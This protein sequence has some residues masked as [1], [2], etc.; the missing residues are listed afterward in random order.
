VVENVT[1]CEQS[2]AP[3][4][5]VFPV[6]SREVGG[7][8]MKESNLPCGGPAFP[9]ISMT[10]ILRHRPRAAVQGNYGRHSRIYKVQTIAHPD[11]QELLFRMENIKWKQT[12]RNHAHEKVAETPSFRK[13][14]IVVLKS[15]NLSVS[16]FDLKFLLYLIHVLHKK[17]II[18]R[19][20]FST[21][22]F[23]HI[24]KNTKISK[25]FLFHAIKSIYGIFGTF[26]YFIMWQSFYNIE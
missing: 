25:I 8:T 5:L 24:L 12:S 26:A 1:I 23:Q 3:P 11:L 13:S 21:S 4:N 15:L 10:R 2:F 6:P 16:P 14:Y 17:Y 9:S 20:S 22:I 18:C 19:N 7:L